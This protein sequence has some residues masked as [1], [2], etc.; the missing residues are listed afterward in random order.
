MQLAGKMLLEYSKIAYLADKQS[1][2]PGTT[3]PLNFV[4][5]PQHPNHGSRFQIFLMS[6]KLLKLQS[7]FMV[8]SLHP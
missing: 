5:P 1:N 4:H 6:S 7:N 2:D 3:E 8:V